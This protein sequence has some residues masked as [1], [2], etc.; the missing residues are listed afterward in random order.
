MCFG[1]NHRPVVLQSVSVERCDPFRGQRFMRQQDQPGTD[2]Q[3][4]SLHHVHN[5]TRLC[6]SV[7]QNEQPDI[8]GNDSGQRQV[9]RRCRPAFAQDQTQASRCPGSD[10]DCSGT[11]GPGWPGQSQFL[12]HRGH[13]CN[14]GLTLSRV[15]K[16]GSASQQIPDQGENCDWKIP[17]GTGTHDVPSLSR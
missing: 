12:F 6:S 11:Y 4:Q 7:A 14:V 17:S 5:W 13:C 2:Q 9:E 8:L 16:V 15:C 3:D 1:K 10:C